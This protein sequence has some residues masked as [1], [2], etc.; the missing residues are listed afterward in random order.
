MKGMLEISRYYAKE[1]DYLHFNKISQRCSSHISK[2]KKATSLFKSCTRENFKVL[3]FPS[4]HSCNKSDPW[5][6]CCWSLPARSLLLESSISAGRIRVGGRGWTD[7][8]AAG[9]CRSCPPRCSPHW[10]HALCSFSANSLQTPPS[11][12]DSPAVTA[13]AWEVS[14]C[15]KSW[16]PVR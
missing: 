11:S 12:K 15:W 10:A 14:T 1:W 16:R 7:E 4:R 13:L 8:D 6:K 2:N 5:A 3:D 9:S